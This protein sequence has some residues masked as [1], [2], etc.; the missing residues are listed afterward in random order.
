MTTN[1]CKTALVIDDEVAIRT[2]LASVLTKRGFQ[3]F[4]AA[5]G[6]EALDLVRALRGRVD[7]VVSDVQ[8]PDGDG[9][10]LV[11]ALRLEYPEIMCI[12]MSA[13]DPPEA[14]RDTPFLP[15]PFP[16][17]DLLQLVSQVMEDAALR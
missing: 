13:F 11:S 16:L 3:A 5:N 9:I 7:L 10:W 4:T 8:M 14:V 17:S 15:K 1:P 12:L 2:L 6:K